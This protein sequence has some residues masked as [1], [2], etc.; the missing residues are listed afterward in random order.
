MLRQNG[1]P[2]GALIIGSDFRALGVA[3]S[4][5]RRHIPCIIIDN[6][7]RSAWLSRYVKKHL[8][9]NGPLDSP[10]FLDFLLNIAEQYHME[11]WVLFPMPDDAVELVARHTSELSKHYQL[12]TQNWEIVKW[13]NDKSLT[14]SMAQDL[15][16][17]CPQT[18][19]PRSEDELQLLEIRFPVIIKPAISLHLQHALRL[20]ALPAHTPEELLTKYRLVAGIIHPHD[21]LIQEIIPGDGSTQFS[22]AAYC[23]NGCMLTSMTARRTRQYPIDYG[24]GSSFVEA[25]Q[26]PEI[27]ELSERLLKQMQV[28]GMLEVE[29]KYD[30]RDKQYKLLDINLRPWG[31]HT[32]AIAC[33]LDFPW[34]QYCDILGTTLTF[35]PP[36][37]GYHWIRLITDL[38]A[39]LAEIKA[40]I[41][42]PKAYLRSL[43]GK[44]AFSVL[45]WRDPL[46]LVGDLFSVARRWFATKR[47][48]ETK[49]N[50][51]DMADDGSANLDSSDKREEDSIS[52]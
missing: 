52:V 28:S 40:G 37:Y 51:I 13:A 39:G 48:N 45:D 12:V 20:K 38:P 19:Y 7:P 32:L 34:I 42:T 6:L 30:R 50:Q 17:S 31:W 18:W 4:L 26:V 47:A 1:K 23:K 25:I 43:L 35:Q 3:R 11:Q 36:R 33:G 46:P 8:L 27:T 2:V 14:Y 24:L 10:D 44:S 41:T 21:I 22:V 15:G 16:V 9:W 5:G 29:F 49:A